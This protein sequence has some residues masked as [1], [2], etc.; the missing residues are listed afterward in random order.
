[1]AV[2][3]RTNFQFPG[4]QSVYHGKVRDVYLFENHLL[5]VAS[6]RISAFDV[7]LPEAI[8][9]KGQV[10]NQLAAYFLKATEDIAPNWLVAVPDPN[11]SFGLRCEPFAIEMV[12]RGYLCLL[13]TSPSPRD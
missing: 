8:P 9:G 12:V 10:L 2:I 3:T 6:D 4:Q 7:I 1:M 13:Y 5:A 11:V